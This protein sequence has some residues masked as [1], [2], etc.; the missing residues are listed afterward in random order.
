MTK[1]TIYNPIN[2]KIPIILFPNCMTH[3]G[4]LLYYI[5]YSLE[6]D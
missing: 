6:L 1:K 3:L 5:L 2:K 4:Q